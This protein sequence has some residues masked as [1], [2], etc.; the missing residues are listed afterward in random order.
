[1]SNRILS[2][3]YNLANFRT[4]TEYREI[5]RILQK[6]SSQGENILWQ[7]HALGKNIVPIN[8]F[9]IDFVSRGVVIYYDY[10]QFR[11]DAGLQLYVKLDYRTSVFKIPEFRLTKNAIHFSFPAEIRSE[12]LRQAERHFFDPSIERFVT[13]K[14]AISS[15]QA[16]AAQ[17]ISMR[18]IDVSRLGL[19]LMVSESNRSFLR[20]NRILW[21]TKLQDMRLNMPIMAE[22]MY[23]NNELDQ[24]Y[25]KRKQKDLKVGLRLSSHFQDEVF[26]NFIR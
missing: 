3:S 15:Q 4:S 20:N 5:L 24:R 8:H 10:N 26:N 1:M 2:M 6:S 23:I 11:V 18:A 16:D 7:S 14:P 19:G 25:V 9:E 13:V 12:E 17:E 21:I 22:V